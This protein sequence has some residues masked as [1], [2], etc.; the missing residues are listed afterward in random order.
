MFAAHP[1]LNGQTWDAGGYAELL[2]SGLI[3]G[4]VPARLQG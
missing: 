1:V 3:L 2:V 4:H